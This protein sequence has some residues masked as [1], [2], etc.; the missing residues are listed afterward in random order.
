MRTLLFFYFL[1]IFVFL[2][3]IL[4]LWREEIQK[5]SATIFRCPMKVGFET[6]WIWKNQEIFDNL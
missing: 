1:E 5:S 3:Q 2:R 4:L 6:V